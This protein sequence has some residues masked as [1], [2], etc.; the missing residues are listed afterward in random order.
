M[1]KF[2]ALEAAEAVGV[3][4][5]AIRRK[6][7]SGKL[8]ASRNDNNE[9][10]IDPAE[11]SRAYP[12]WSPDAPK[13]SDALPSG[14][15][16][17]LSGNEIKALKREIEVLGEK[18]EKENEERRRERDQAQAEIDRLNSQLEKAQDLAAGQLRL[19]EAAQSKPTKTGWFGRR[20][21]A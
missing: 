5:S 10:E 19:L 6:I 14:E 18:I 17:G 8:S 11:L 13:R 9:Y 21:S 2:S 15:A 7:Q 20:K 1:N 4:K 16:K 12:N 3:S